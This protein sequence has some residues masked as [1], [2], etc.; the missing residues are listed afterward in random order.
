MLLIIAQ[1]LVILATCA[2]VIYLIEMVLN[3]RPGRIIY[4][5]TDTKSVMGKVAEIIR[6]RVKDPSEYILYEPG[7]GLATASR[8]LARQFRWKEVIA[9]ELRYSLLAGAYVR[10]W[11]GPVRLVRADILKYDVPAPSVV[12]CYLSGDLLKRLYEQG[13]FEDRLVICLTFVIPGV[14]PTEQTA[15]DGWQKQ[16][17][18]YDFRTA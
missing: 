8:S 9:T 18:V 10:N 2:Y 13:K 16:L 15:I 11:R 1:V 4:V 7:S 5:G 6:N 3:S 17:T 14:T 12:Y